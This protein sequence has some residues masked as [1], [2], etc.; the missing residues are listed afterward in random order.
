M[1]LAL[2]S[3]S[4]MGFRINSRNINMRKPMTHSTE[5]FPVIKVKLFLQYV[6]LTNVLFYVH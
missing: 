5:M 2:V 4:Q 3:I 6:S 1:A